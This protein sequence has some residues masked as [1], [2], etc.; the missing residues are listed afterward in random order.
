MESLNVRSLLNKKFILR[1]ITEITSQKLDFLF[2][3]K[4]FFGRFEPIH[5][6]GPLDCTF[7]ST[8]RLVGREVGLAAIFKDRI[9]PAEVY[10]SFELQMVQFEVNNNP[11]L[12]V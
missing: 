12:C 7:F 4:T 8:S 5:W 1:D 3:T 11:I 9:I 10:G 6:T 2:L